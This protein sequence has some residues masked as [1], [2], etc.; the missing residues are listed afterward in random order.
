MKSRLQK[1][2]LTDVREKAKSEGFYDGRFR[3]RVVPD[4]KKKASAEACRGAKGKNCL[5][6]EN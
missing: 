2:I 6:I 1:L 3:S 4:K 5:A